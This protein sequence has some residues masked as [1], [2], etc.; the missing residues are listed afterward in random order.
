VGDVADLIAPLP[1]HPPTANNPYAVRPDS[2]DQAG[3]FQ[4]GDP[5][6]LYPLTVTHSVQDGVDRLTIDGLTDDAVAESINT[7]FAQAQDDYRAAHPDF[8]P[9]TLCTTDAC[10]SDGHWSS[11]T[12]QSQGETGTVYVFG[13][14]LSLYEK[15]YEY[16]EDDP[17][18][19]R[20]ETGAVLNIRLDTGEPFTLTDV[21]ADGAP[22]EGIL[23]DVYRQDIVLRADATSSPEPADTEAR[24]IN[25]ITGY[26]ATE[27][28]VF[29][30]HSA[31]AASVTV[32]FG[33]H[34]IEPYLESYWKS[35][36]IGKR[37]ATSNDGAL[38]TGAP[39]S[40]YTYSTMFQEW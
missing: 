3:D 21:F 4:A 22:V 35:V 8:K 9:T 11:Y 37:F 31:L 14:V 29:Y 27:K 38:Y 15:S 23:A 39:Q 7:R 26:R 10:W 40:G 30:V 5:W 2:L 16:S 34:T 19:G 33:N 24:V 12:R 13:N 20:E 1:Y 32:Q 28:P 36:A 6:P 18:E 25:M 17:Y